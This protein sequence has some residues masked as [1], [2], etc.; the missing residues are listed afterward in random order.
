M[1]QGTGMGKGIECYIGYSVKASLQREREIPGWYLSK[2][3][4]E[5]KQ[6]MKGTV[7]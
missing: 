7:G 1:T 6:Q 3:T 4:N 2:D 5:I